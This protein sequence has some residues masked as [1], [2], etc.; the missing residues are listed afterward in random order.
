MKKTIIFTFMAMFITT[1]KSWVSVGSSPGFGSCTYST[2]QQA[3][4]SNEAEIRVL[5]NQDFFE[6][7]E[8]DHSVDIKGG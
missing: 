5:N 7:I 2:I 3:L 8:I 6:N 1:A 4:D